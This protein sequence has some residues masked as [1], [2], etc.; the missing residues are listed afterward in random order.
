MLKF[1]TFAPALFFMCKILFFCL[2]HNFFSSLLIIAQ[3]FLLTL[4]SSKN[5]SPSHMNFSFLSDI[6]FS[7]TTSDDS[8]DDDTMYYRLQQVLPSAQWSQHSFLHF[9]KRKACLHEKNIT[10][11]FSS[12]PHINKTLISRGQ[13]GFASLLKNQRLRLHAGK[14]Y[15]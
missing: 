1:F 3:P 7:S 13:L 8:S 14:S 2:F 6:I 12:S 5:P 9:F 10:K 15:F 4:Y 11:F